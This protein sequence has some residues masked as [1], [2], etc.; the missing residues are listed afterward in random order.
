M[1]VALLQY[2]IVWAEVQENL[3]LTELR[4][5]AIAGQADVALLPEM[6][7]TGF[8]TDN[9]ALAEEM[10]GPTVANLKRWAREFDLAIA[11]SFMCREKNKLVNR[12]F[13][14]R[15]DGTS[16]FIDKRH[17]YAHGG[18]AD[19]FEAGKERKISIYKGV[20]FCLQIT[21]TWL[22]SVKTVV[23][24]ALRNELYVV[25]NIHHEGEG[26]WFQTKMATYKDN[27]V[28]TK[29]K[30]YWTQIANKFK[31]YD[32]HLLFAGAN[33]PGEGQQGQ[34]GRAHV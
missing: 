24:Y 27:T 31:N 18:E 23:D 30:N 5:A 9:P 15:P 32:E 25:L 17:L 26:G 22:D 34:I 16:D 2:P 3:R 6:F 20:R 28:D 33:E 21:E 14:I 19:F 13:F 12:G 11:G 4:L 7:T 10:D 1:K 29:M 8:C